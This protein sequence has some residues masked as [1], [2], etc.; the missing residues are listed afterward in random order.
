MVINKANEIPQDLSK[1]LSVLTESDEFKALYDTS[2]VYSRSIFDILRKNPALTLR[3]DSPIYIRFD[4]DRY[5]SVY[6]EHLYLELPPYE[7]K[8]TWKGNLYQESA[9][10]TV[11]P[12]LRIHNRT[13]TPDRF[14]FFASSDG[15]TLKVAV[16]PAVWFAETNEPIVLLNLQNSVKRKTTTIDIISSQKG[17]VLNQDIS[18]FVNRFDIDELAQ[19][20]EDTR[21]FLVS[22]SKNNAHA[23]MRSYWV[24]GKQRMVY[25]MGEKFFW[26]YNYTNALKTAY[27]T[28]SLLRADAQISLDYVLNKRVGDT[29]LYSQNKLRRVRNFKFAVIA[30]DGDGKIRLMQDYVKNREIIDP[31]NALAIEKLNQEY[32]FFSNNKKER[33]QWGNTNLLHLAYGPGS[34]IK[35][36]VFA[37]IAS[38]LNLG[39]ENLFLQ[40]PQADAFSIQEGNSKASANQYAGYL[41]PKQ[42]GWIDEHGER[43]GSIKPVQY[44]QTSSNFYHSILMFLGSYHRQDFKKNNQYRL[45]NVLSAKLN[46]P[47][48]KFPAL[49]VS[50][51]SYR[52]KSFGEKAWPRSSPDE[53]TYFGNE[54]S[55]LA[56]GIDKNL[57]LIVEDIDKTDR[58]IKGKGRVDFADSIAFRKLRGKQVGGFLWSFPEQSY[59][60]QAERKHPNALTNFFNGL[61]NPTLGGSPY[62]V[63]PLKMT[64]MFGK[65]ISQNKDYSLHLD[66]RSLAQSPWKI[67]STWQRGFPNFMRNNVLKGMEQVLVGTGTAAQ[68]FGGVSTHNGYFCYAKTGTI[69]E[70]KQN[71]SKRLALVISKNDL[72]QDATQANKFYVVYFTANEAENQ[73]WGLY[74]AIINQIMA[75]KSFK[76]YMGE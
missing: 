70:G 52:L 16:L 39:W 65:M 26:P 8:T 50:G 5:Q 21:N 57:G 15:G 62:S 3:Q 48:N 14:P 44:L 7:D 75:S 68:M 38:Q 19:V 51:I 54:K 47:K 4:S 31:N 43:L 29:V 22:F 32:F 41:F 63:T 40:A 72:L 24:N 45:E 59:F 49:E 17:E 23:F 27:T 64:E 73:D 66:Q 11:Y 30:A 33:D 74:R 10:S 37:S 6:N 71:D 61:K 76:K 60:I 56:V 58:S 2:D 28:D 42:K 53:S 34:S 25:P 18:G 67:D 55:L 36:L 35:P 69:K 1:I 46:D 12:V 13:I 9:D 20:S